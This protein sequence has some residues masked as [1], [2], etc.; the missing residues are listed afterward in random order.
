[1]SYPLRLCDYCQSWH[2]RPCGEGCQ[3]HAAGETVDAHLARHGS[4][5]EPQEPV[6]LVAC[7]SCAQSGLMCAWCHGEGTVPIETANRLG[8]IVAPKGRS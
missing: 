1:M 8:W 3:W 4:L 7:Q 2:S 5:H 6:R